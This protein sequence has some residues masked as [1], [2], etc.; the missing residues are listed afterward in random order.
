VLEQSP[1]LLAAVRERFGDE[2]FSPEG[3]L[4]RR[5]LGK[6]VFF[7]A[8]HIRWLTNL[9][10][11]RIHRLWME[12]VEQSPSD[13]I[14]FD[15]ALIVEWGI[16]QEFDCLVVVTAPEDLVRERLMHGG[17]LTQDEAAARQ[18]QQITPAAKAAVADRVIVNNG[19]LADL[20]RQVDSF[21][22]DVIIPKL[23][24][25]RKQRNAAEN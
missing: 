19:T 20:R 6:R 21:W 24:L 1:E 11:P 5:E 15:A 16:E 14:V 7:S 13:V 4:L 10:F 9:T 17:S 25:R 12:A 2:V 18:K 22:Q 23:E 8:E 3:Q